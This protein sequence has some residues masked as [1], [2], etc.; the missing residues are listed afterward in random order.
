[1]TG[2]VFAGSLEAT[3]AEVRALGGEPHVLQ[4][5][6]TSDE[7]VAA[8]FRQVDAEQGRVDV[9]VNSVW[10]GYERMV[11]DGQFT[12]SEPFWKQPLWRWDAMFQAGVRAAY[13]ASALAARSMV[14]AGSGLIVNVSFWAAQKHIA[15]V[16]YGA[17]K[18]ATDKL[19]ADMAAEPKVIDRSGQVLVA[20]AL[21]EQY[22]F[23]DVDG[24][25]PRPLTLNDV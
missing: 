21:G 2:W 18:A 6:H 19:T 8:L 25:R 1:M 20:A 3:A 4:C 5:D 17:S 9:L 22:D 23:S 12:W 7:Q 11:E 24:A 16:E 10:G 13:V 14:A 15:N